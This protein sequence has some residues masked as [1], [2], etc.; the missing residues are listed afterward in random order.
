MESLD[1]R[2]VR[3]AQRW[4]ESGQPV[5]LCTVLHTYG[6]APRVPGSLLA[7]TRS[8]AFSGSLSGGCIEDDFITRLSRGSFAADSQIIRYGAGGLPAAVALPCGGSIDVLVERMTAADRPQLAAMLA[9]LEGRQALVRR[10]TLPLRAGW[11]WDA[12]G[13]AGQ[14]IHWQ[15][16]Q[17]VIPMGAAPRLIVA[18]YSAVAHDCILLAQMLGFEV[19]LCEHREEQQRQFRQDFPAPEAALRFSPR[20]PA[21][22][23][24]LESAHAR[25]AIVALTHDPRID[26]LTLAEAVNTRAFYIGAMGSA[27]NSQRRRERLATVGGLSAAELA[28][29]QAPIGL[30]IGSKTPA[31]IALAVM[32]QIVM[33]KNRLQSPADNCAP[34]G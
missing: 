15:G 4:L 1:I 20:F 18:G 5:W 14:Q 23:L 29:I 16:E 8:G 34:T 27:R 30:P 26:D 32:A 21:R 24:E 10:I 25:C 6:S 31:E 3:Q 19:L 33:A 22:Y 9:A 28:R 13:A 12:G 7:A 11:Q 2:V 17:V